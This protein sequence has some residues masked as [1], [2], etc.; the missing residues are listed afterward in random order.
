MSNPSSQARLS[1]DLGVGK[2]IVTSRSARQNPPRLQHSPSLPN[3]WFPPHSG[4]LPSQMVGNSR[5][6]LQ[7]P[8]TPPP[9]MAS[10]VT[11][12]KIASHA[13]EITALRPPENARDTG[14]DCNSL[15]PS[16]NDKQQDLEA[17]HSLLTPPLTPSS[18]I[19]TR[20]DSIGTR[21]NDTQ[22]T[23]SAEETDTEPDASRFLLVSNVSRHVHPDVLRAAITATLRDIEAKAL[24]K[25]GDFLPF[26]TSKS[27]TVE[28]AVKG[29]FARRQESHGIIML[30]FHDVRHAKLAKGALSTRVAGPLTECVSS[31]DDTN[32]WLNC[33]FITAEEL[34]KNIGNSAFLASTDG[35]FYLIVEFDDRPGV[36]TGKGPHITEANGKMNMHLPDSGC[37]DGDECNLNLGTL[38]KFLESFGDLRYFTP[39]DISPGKERDK[40][41]ART[42]HVEYFD[43][44][45]A[46]TASVELHEQVLFGKKLTVYRREVSDILL[47]NASPDGQSKQ[48]SLTLTH[49]E[50]DVA[51]S[52]QSCSIRFKDS[53]F[54]ILPPGKHSHTRERLP[55]AGSAPISIAEPDMHAVIPP[56]T[57]GLD[58]SP[59]FFYTSNHNNLFTPTMR[60]PNAHLYTGGAGAHTGEPLSPVK[61][62]PDRTQVHNGDGGVHDFRYWNCDYQSGGYP[63]YY[64]RSD[65]FY[66]REP[67]SPNPQGSSAPGFYQSNGHPCNSLYPLPHQATLAYGLEVENSQI[68]PSAACQNWGMD[69]A[70]AMSVG[71]GT[72]AAHQPSLSGSAEHWYLDVQPTALTG[73]PYYPSP[74]PNSPNYNIPYYQKGHFPQEDT[75]AHGPPLFISN[76]RTPT[77]PCPANGASTTSQEASSSSRG[78]L[79]PP[80]RNQLNIARIEDGQDT[81]TTVMIKNIPN[82]M[83][84]RELLNFIHK[85][86]PRRIDFLYLRM[87]F[88][89]GCNVGYAFVNFIH[90]QDL[91]AFA[92]KKLGEKWNM[93]SSEKVLQ[94]SYANY[95]GKEALVEKFKN[96]CIMDEREA[97]RPKIFYSDG[98]EQGLPEPFPAPTHLRRKERS[99]H[100][101]GALYVPGIGTG[102]QTQLY[103]HVGPRRQSQ[104]AEEDRSRGTDSLK[105]RSGD[106]APPSVTLTKR[107]KAHR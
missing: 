95:Q 61:I 7:R 92:K 81:R 63:Y 18:S 23:S 54:R 96:S 99:S 13:D 22:A 89:N 10:Q 42:F 52:T 14:S 77:P 60:E 71:S 83:S 55:I 40:D 29:V 1:V 93:F 102:L 3:I 48:S 28:D 15:S 27:F 98:P 9:N 6:R 31:G 58:A 44:R 86:C 37:N 80:E 72:L 36:N 17:L 101:R 88:S 66:C 53:R 85:V 16:K 70:M 34:A 32:T 105:I 47:D 12:R 39:A 57:C 90:V 68:H 73:C 62:D 8:T 4:P 100:N 67:A 107:G 103:A 78:P 24:E 51:T 76:M 21:D 74:T 75:L 65:Y 69:H 46:S 91:L 106:N 82:K 50:K 19:V 5:T 26:K 45:V 41:H 64:P 20:S 11:Q 30:A 79:L 38:K 43:A 59:T 84:D 97:W 104:Q 33:R 49:Q 94:M 25:N 2:K 87:D 35:G 56:P